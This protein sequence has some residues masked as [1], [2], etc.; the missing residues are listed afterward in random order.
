L[1]KIIVL[2]TRVRKFVLVGQVGQNKDCYYF[3]YLPIV[4]T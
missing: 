2:Y 1:S 3:S 4:P